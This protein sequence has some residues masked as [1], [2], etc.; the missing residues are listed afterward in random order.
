M[1][2]RWDRDGSVKPSRDRSGL[3][4]VAY[5]PRSRKDL[6][7][8]GL[9]LPGSAEQDLLSA[10]AG[11][12]ERAFPNSIDAL[13]RSLLRRRH[14]NPGNVINCLIRRHPSAIASSS[15]RT[16]AARSLAQP[17]VSTSPS[18][19]SPRIAGPIITTELVV[20]GMSRAPSKWSADIRTLVTRVT[21]TQRVGLRRERP[22][23]AFTAAT[24]V[25]SVWHSSRSTF[26]RQGPDPSFASLRALAERFAHKRCVSGPQGVRQAVD[27]DRQLRRQRDRYG[28]GRGAWAP[29]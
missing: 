11:V 9:P 22:Q 7:R 2:R 6:E 25:S 26:H 16:G 28:P 15:A 27:F 18:S 3:R 5:L 10:V 17:Q 12:R 24:T 29:R 4:C 1:C 8:Y 14:E 20:E 23:R 21:H 19:S 13:A